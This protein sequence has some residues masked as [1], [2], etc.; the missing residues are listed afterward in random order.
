MLVSVL[1]HQP[2]G[3]LP[4]LLWIPA[5]SSHGPNLSPVGASRNPGAVQNLAG[6]KGDFFSIKLSSA[7]APTSV[8]DPATV[9]YAR[10]GYFA[11]GNLTVK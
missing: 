9:F 10:A 2:D 7:T 4:Q 11:G 5:W 1:E 6:S 3:P 8:L